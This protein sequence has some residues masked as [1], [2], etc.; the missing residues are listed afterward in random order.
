MKDAEFV[1]TGKVWR[2]EGPG[3]WHFLT[4]DKKTAQGI[5]FFAEDR[6]SKLGS[7]KVRAKIGKTSWETSL[8]PTKAGE[9]LLAIKASV[10]KAEKVSDGDRVRVKLELI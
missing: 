3:G 4:V 10:R 6:A 7:V 2:Y 1:T 5:R 9:Y 8:F